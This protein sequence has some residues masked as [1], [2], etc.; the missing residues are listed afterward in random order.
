VLSERGVGRNAAADFAKP[1]R[2]RLFLER[3]DVPTGIEAEDA[4]LRR[5]LGIRRLRRNGDI[6]SLR[7]VRPDQLLVIHPIQ[8]VAG[9]DEVMA[10]RMPCE[11]TCRLTYGVGCSLEPVRIVGCLLGGEDFDKTLREVVEP[12][13]HRDVTIERGGIELRQNV[14]AADVRVQ[15][16][17]HGNVDQP[18]LPGDRNRGLGPRGGQWKQPR[19]LAAAKND[20]ERIHGHQHGRRAKLQPPA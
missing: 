18:V 16:V 1:V 7:F 2:V 14:D 11:V 12:V 4:H 15:A 10:R 3:D 9:E 17:A 6:R 19:A 5:G 8:M 20:R 13:R